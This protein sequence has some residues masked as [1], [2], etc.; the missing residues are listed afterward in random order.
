MDAVFNISAKS[1]FNQAI[2]NFRQFQVISVTFVLLHLNKRAQINQFTS[3]LVIQL[4]FA[5]SLFFILTLPDK[6]LFFSH[7]LFLFHWKSSFWAALWLSLSASFLLY[8]SS[9]SLSS[10]L[11]ALLSALAFSAPPPPSLPPLCCTA[12]QRQISVLVPVRQRH[13]SCMLK[14]NQLMLIKEAG[15]GHLFTQNTKLIWITRW[16]VLHLRNW[17]ISF[18]P[19]G[20]NLDGGGHAPDAGVTGW[21]TGIRGATGKRIFMFYVSE[22]VSLSWIFGENTCVYYL[23]NWE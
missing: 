4:N 15:Y 7:L 12:V 21:L 10:F 18:C 2:L 20:F 22:K 6:H 9:P 8:L 5:S 13:A 19:P 14:P 1:K 17:K 3:I 16:N 11:S 23:S